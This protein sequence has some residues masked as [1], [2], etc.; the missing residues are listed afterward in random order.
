MNLYLL[1]LGDCWLSNVSLEL[2]AV[3]STFD[4]A[5]ELACENSKIDGHRLR[6]SD[7]NELRINHQTYGLNDN[8]M[9]SKIEVD[10]LDI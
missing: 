3:C 2:I 1:Y 4:K 5:I 7:I 9:I 10:T 8:Y 6:E